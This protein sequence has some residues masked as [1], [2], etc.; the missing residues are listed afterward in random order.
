MALIKLSI[1]ESF[2]EHASISSALTKDYTL[3][4][5]D[6]DQNNLFYDGGDSQWTPEELESLEEMGAYK[7]TVNA[8]R[9]AIQA[10]TGLLTSAKPKFNCSPIGYKD[11]A[12]SGISEQILDDCYRNS[13]GSSVISEI[14]LNALKTN[15]S[16]AYIKSTSDNKTTFE[17]LNYKEVITAPCKDVMFRDAEWIATIK[18]VDQN[19]LKA[20]FGLDSLVTTVPVE[21]QT[22]D[23]QYYYTRNKMRTYD[24][25]KD[26]VQVVTK[27]KR[28]IIKKED[29]STR[30]R[31][32]K[33]IY[34]GY[35]HVYEEYLPESIRDYPI[36]PFYSD[37]SDN[38]FKYS[39]GHHM[40]DPQRFVNKMFNETVRSAQAS[41]GGKIVTRKNEIPNGDI[42]QLAIEWSK[43]NGIVVMNPGAQAPTV[44]SAQPLNNA[45]FTMYKDAMEVIGTTT[46]AQNVKYGELTLDPNKK[47]D[48]E[49]AITANMKVTATI[50]ETFLSQLGKVLLQY[51]QG[52][53]NPDRITEIV[54]GMMYIQDIKDAQAKGLDTT[55]DEG[56]MNWTKK[57]MDGKESLEKIED[58]I[59]KTKKAIEVTDALADI[60]REK[61]NIATDVDIEPESYTSTSQTKTFR[62]IYSMAKEGILPPEIV[63]DYLPIPDKEALKAKVG[64]LRSSARQIQSLN[65]Q[66]EELTKKLEK[67]DQE[68]TGL[69]RKVITTKHEAGIDYQRKDMM[70]KKTDQKKSSAIDKKIKAADARLDLRE[71]LMDLKDE[72]EERPQETIS[73]LENYLDNIQ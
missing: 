61:K 44:V 9:T 35:A 51:V 60:I 65:N 58:M 11:N 28:I 22:F 67:M 47:E 5:K 45:F 63:V 34:L 19:K 46:A 21:W 31:I 55:S 16:Y 39:D 24:K 50:F 59:F 12:I 18:W 26:Q 8:V 70:L 27:F 49:D 1:Q 10:T 53:T 25:R 6:C 3:H 48:W 4:Q 7:L 37:Y 32:L 36:I 71:L 33:R 69:A 72:Y 54:D 57:M 56:I 64:S 73:A 30:S 14:V 17:F 20:L 40:K 13:L 42:D 15:I 62:L 38:E 29:G 23:S 68:N 41:N 2:L 43:P 52:Y 66:L